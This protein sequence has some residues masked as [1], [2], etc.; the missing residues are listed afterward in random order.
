MTRGVWWLLAIFGALVV[1]K[2]LASA[3]AGTFTPQ[4]QFHLSGNLLFYGFIA[5]ILVYCIIH[6]VK[7]FRA[8]DDWTRWT[9][10]FPLAGYVVLVG[11]VWAWFGY[12]IYHHAVVIWP[13]IV[14]GVL[15]VLFVVRAVAENRQHEETRKRLTTLP[16]PPSA[17]G[18]SKPDDFKGW[19]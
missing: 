17:S 1:Y 7:Q 15:A 19:S 3:I 6:A 18:A 8:Y 12:F 16:D 4:E 9:G 11:G 5:A 10:L 13:V 14:V 2:L